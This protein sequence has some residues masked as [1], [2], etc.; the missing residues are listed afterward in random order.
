MRPY[1][2]IIVDSFRAAIASRVLYIM[3]ALITLL[4]LVV[5]PLHLTETLD[6][7]LRQFQH[8]EKSDAIIARLIE[9]GETGRTK[10]TTRVWSLLSKDTQDIVRKLHENKDKVYDHRDPA[11]L[12]KEQR[13]DMAKLVD[14]LNEMIESPSFYR[15]EDWDRFSKVPEA[16]SLLEDG[17]DNLS[18]ERK[19][20]LNR[21]LIGKAI[22]AL[23]PPEATSFNVYYWFFNN[24]GAW[25]FSSSRQQV[26]SIVSSV[27]AALF[28]KFLLSIGLLVGIVVT[29]NVIPQMFDPGSLNLLLS[30]PITR[31]GLYLTRFAGGCTQIAI[32]ATYLFTGTWLWLGL[33]IGVWDQAFLW[34]IPIYILVFAI[35]YS[36]SALIG[37]LYRSPILAVVATV[38]FWA[39]CFSVGTSYQIFYALMQNQRLY[40]PLVT[41]NGVSAVD[42]FG[43]IVIWDASSKKWKVTV[44]NSNGPLKDAIAFNRFLL[45]I[46][47]TPNQ[48]RPTLDPE[49]K[50]VVIGLTPPFPPQP[51][52]FSSYDGYV[53][54]PDLKQFSSV[55]N[56]P[57]K[58]MAMFATDNGLLLCDHN[59]KFKRWNPKHNAQIDV[60]LITE[61]GIPQSAGPDQPVQVTTAYSVAMNHSNQEIAI[62][63]AKGGQHHI[64]IFKPTDDGEYVQDRSGVIDVATNEKIKCFIA[65]ANNTI[66]AVAGNGRVVGLDATSMEPLP[67]MKT[68]E[69]SCG[70]ETIATSPDGKW[71]AMVYGNQHLWLMDVDNDRKLYRPSVTGN[72][73]VSSVSFDA[74]SRLCV[75]D[76]ENRLTVYE[77][78]NLK[79]VL[80]FTPKDSLFE[81]GYRYLVSPLYT[82]FPKPGEFHKVTSYLSSTRDTANNP[83]A[84]LIFE[85]VERHPLSPL[86][87]GLGFMV[88]MLGLSC[89]FFSRKDF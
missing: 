65:F 62:H 33:A 48:I 72:R 38:V 71:I 74:E 16:K 78:A 29:A 37:L 68:C 54:D 23:A 45:K 3:L 32:C 4:F 79:S 86:W 80:E 6:W 59:G 82:V 56:F 26:F 42:G 2:A 27:T 69:T 75:F 30:K 49:S 89:W 76:R 87:S 61:A 9:R 73:D 40:D 19:R 51:D 18:L 70:I 36:I 31:S 14:G 34:S 44:E 25:S 10:T 20:R 58:T 83:A 67:A 8:F 11:S 35:Y 57:P 12:W 43:E 50:Q 53:S 5:G 55:G 63:K 52:G 85:P 66:I 64:V 46:K 7:K 39:V 77:T 47:T 15:E 88:L 41:E 84:D 21:L 81:T 1:L 22:P 28:D 17:F 24:D 13:E 60:A